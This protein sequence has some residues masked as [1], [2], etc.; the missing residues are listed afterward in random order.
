VQVVVDAE[1]H[2]NA[3]LVP[4]EAIVRDG[5]ETAVFIARDDKAHRQPVTIGLTDADHVEIV[6]GIAAGDNVIVDGQA[7]L[8]DDATIHVSAGGEAEP[9]PPADQDRGKR[10]R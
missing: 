9:G 6:K 3:V 5:D 10:S 2:T 7:G 1:H 4:R 8:P